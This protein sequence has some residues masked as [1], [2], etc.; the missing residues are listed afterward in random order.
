MY[1]RNHSPGSGSQVTASGPGVP[2]FDPTVIG[3]IGFIRANLP[4]TNTFITGTS[5]AIS[6][7]TL[8][9][10]R[11]KKGSCWEVWHPWEWIPRG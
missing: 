1:D 5:R 9:D 4:Q 11:C 10:L 2:D 8:E 7:S 3:S 6:S